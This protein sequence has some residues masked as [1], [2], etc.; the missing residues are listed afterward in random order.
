[1]SIDTLIVVGTAFPAAL[2][3]LMGYVLTTR[4][5][6]QKTK[7]RYEATF[8]VLAVASVGFVI[9][10]G[11]RNN[12][13]ASKLEGNISGLRNQIERIAESQG[14]PEGQSAKDLAN[15]IIARFSELQSRIDDAESKIAVVQHPPQDSM[16]IYQNGTAVASVQKGRISGDGK[17]VFFDRL[18]DTQ[19]RN[20][21]T[22]L[23][24]DRWICRVSDSLRLLE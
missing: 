5:P 14:L 4:P 16:K 1:M 19:K 11:V 23:V 10:G 6:S 13:A 22:P 21:T 7:W 3:G 18:S 12:N 9:W 20:S 17:S 8:A 15:A 24:S 2:M